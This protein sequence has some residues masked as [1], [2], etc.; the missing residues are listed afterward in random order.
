M[1]AIDTNILVRFLV[2]DD[3]KQ[4]DKVYNLFKDTEKQHEELYIPILV[5][6]E[7]IWVLESVYEIKRS[8]LLDTLSQLTL[9][10]ILC[11]ENLSAIQSFILNAKNSNFDLSD[12]LIGYS[13]KLKSCEKVM[14]FDKKASKHQFFELLQ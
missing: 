1:I 2:K 4:A 8:D 7:V 6:L 9:M 12:L 5:I 3:A 13:T 14:T 10:P 11:F